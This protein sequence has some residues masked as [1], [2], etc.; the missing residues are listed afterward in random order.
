MET[1]IAG[2][3]NEFAIDALLSMIGGGEP[4]LPVLDP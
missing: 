2:R 4:L 1:T 3:I